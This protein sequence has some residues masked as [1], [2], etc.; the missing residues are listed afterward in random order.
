MTWV[1]RIRIVYQAFFLVLFLWL[2]SLLAVGDPH[3]LPYSVFHR[4][5]PLSAIA[6]VLS[7]GTLP[8]VLLVAVAMVVL[9]IVLGRVLCGWVCPLGTL[10]QLS[11][12][13]LSSRSR[14]ESQRVNRY[15]RWF[16]IK[17]YILAG[18]L[19]MAVLGSIQTGLLDPL[20]LTARG[21]ASGAWPLLPERSPVPGGWLAAGLL[22]A[23][24]I[25]SRWI[26]RLF[27]RAFCPLGALL[28]VFAR[29]SLFRI[30]RAGDACTSCDQCTFA[31]Q[32]GDEPLAEHRV[33]E[34]LV[35]LNCTDTCSEAALRY[36]FLAPA[37]PQPAKPDVE[38]RYLL[39]GAIGGLVAAPLLAAAGGGRATS[40][41]GAIR[42]PGALA[43]PQFLE[44]CV[45]CSLCQQVCPTSALQP[46]ITQAGVEGFWTP[47]LV[48]RRGWCEFACTRCSEVCPTGA[49]APLK[50]ERKTGYDGKP[51]VR[52]GT[53]FVDRNRCLPWSMTTPCIVCEEMC[54]TDPKAIW[55]EEVTERD[56]D[57]RPVQLQRPHVEP[58]RCVGC[59][60]CENRCPV[61]EHAAIR[62]SSVGESRDPLN[63]MLLE[64]GQPASTEPRQE[65]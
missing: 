55:V 28:G 1:R 29:F 7:S 46:A 16:A 40:R 45:K 14:R 17:Y 42:P 10:Q 18:L 50:P 30:H 25:A 43:E 59:G 3:D 51:P 12:W 6:V 38:R 58:Q 22:L 13:V 33:G 63:Q 11:S 4:A 31:C 35:C 9:T 39:G 44:R 2:L 57:G 62:V 5:D 47:V 53:A 48:P 15:R 65:V 56:R 8:A 34:C 52:I 32:G 19:V 54:P 27:C 64:S 26:P 36:R 21:L 61:G 41:P 49:I 23:I 24:V 37:A 20:S 60:I